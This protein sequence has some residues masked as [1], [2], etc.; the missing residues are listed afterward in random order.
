MVSYLSNIVSYPSNMVNYV[1]NMVNYLSNIESDKVTILKK[2]YALP[3]INL[4]MH[5]TLHTY[6]EEDLNMVMD[7]KHFSS[8]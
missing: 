3:E 6:V 2:I 5:I 8:L 1:S 7:T 4:G